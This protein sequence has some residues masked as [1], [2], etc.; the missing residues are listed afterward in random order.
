MTDEDPQSVNIGAEQKYGRTW[1][2]LFHP[3]VLGLLLIALIW[4]LKYAGVVDLIAAIPLWVVVAVCSSLIFIPWLIALEKANATLVLVCDDI[5]TLSEWR[6]GAHYPIDIT[7][8]PLSFIS[9]SGVRRLF[10]TSFD[11]ES[12]TAEAH[13]VAGGT[14]FDFIRDGNAFM[15]LSAAY[16]RTLRGEQIVKEMVGVEAMRAGGRVADQMLRILYSSLDMSELE[17]A[18]AANNADPEITPEDLT[19]SSL[20][21]EAI[22]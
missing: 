20:D 10:L 16:S 18:L 5:E 21:D 3:L 11:P 22:E 4:A 17:E 13:A 9:R 2:D 8:A 1:P 19:T 14:P 6:V 7:G 15:Q 12:H